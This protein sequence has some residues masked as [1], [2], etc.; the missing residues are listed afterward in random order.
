MARENTCPDCRE[1]ISLAKRNCYW[2]D[3][4]YSDK[5]GVVYKGSVKGLFGL[6]KKPEDMTNEE[7]DAFVKESVKRF[8]KSGTKIATQITEE[9]AQA[10]MRGEWKP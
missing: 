6:D 5:N 8:A 9:Q 2:C 1:K 7:R 10:F 4:E 3:N